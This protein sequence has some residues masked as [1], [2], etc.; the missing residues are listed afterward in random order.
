[1]TVCRA[2]SGDMCDP[3]EHCTAIPTQPCPSNIILPS[4]TVCRP[5]AGV[6]DTAE[7]C[8]GTTGAPC[9]VNTV[10]PVGTPCEADS[11]QCTVDKCNSLGLCVFSNPLDC[12]D[13]NTCT[14]DSC[15]AG[16]GC[17]H[18]GTPSNS[19][20]AATRATFQFRNVSDNRRD[21]V[22]FRWKGGPVSMSQLGNPTQTSRYELCIYDSDDVVALGVPPGPGWSTIGS[23]SAPRGYRYK[24][25]FGQNQ[26][27]TKITLK[28][29]SVQSA[30]LQVSGK[31][32]LLPD[33]TIPFLLP[34]TAQLYNSDGQCWDMEFDLAH[35]RRNAD[36]S[37][38]GKTP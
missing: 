19:C 2:G 16:S 8:T 32:D 7:E 29:S 4:G 22:K 26:G 13:G 34:L 24:D 25:R 30:K 5:S 33:P 1:L 20:Q 11:D 6:C 28:A 23:P 14:Q 15:S 18:S 21:K 27:V 3:A 31:G 17:V 38:Y 9:P 10:S 36:G 12:N 37:Y 35:T